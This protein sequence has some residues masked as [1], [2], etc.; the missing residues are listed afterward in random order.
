MIMQGGQ[1]KN[2]HLPQTAANKVS[3]ATDTARETLKT[4]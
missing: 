1:M 4:Q 2:E 3:D